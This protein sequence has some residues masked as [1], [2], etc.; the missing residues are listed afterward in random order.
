MNFYTS[1]IIL[2]TLCY[3]V[4]CKSLNDNCIHNGENGVCNLLKNCEKAKL[5]LNLEGKLYTKCS[6][7][8]YNSEPLVCC[9]DLAIDEEDTIS[10]TS[11]FKI[12]LVNH[13]KNYC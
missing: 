2:S 4:F 12:I 10:D 8:Y 13:L 6:D 1:L 3:S 7:R 5:E 11:K 9:L